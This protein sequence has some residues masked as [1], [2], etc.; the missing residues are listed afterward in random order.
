MTKA[1]LSLSQN[2]EL[3]WNQRSSKKVQQKNDEP[4]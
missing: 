1:R 3:K 4:N 2:A